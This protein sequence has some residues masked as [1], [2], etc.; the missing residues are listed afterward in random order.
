MK[1][2]RTHITH[3]AHDIVV[4]GMP[5]Q[6]HM[7]EDSRLTGRTARFRWRAV[8]DLQGFDLF[9]FGETEAAALQKIT[10]LIS[11]YQQLSHP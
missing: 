1:D 8:V 7:D 9:G 4:G 3:T 2:I 11:S 10:D 6:V 5:F